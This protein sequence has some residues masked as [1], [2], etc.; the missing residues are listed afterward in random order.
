MRLTTQTLF[1][2]ALLLAL[3]SGLVACGSDDQLS[4]NEYMDRIDSAATVAGERG[5][6]LVADAVGSGDVTPVQ[7]QSFLA[8][9]LDDLRIPLQET[10]DEL[11]PPDQL[12]DLHERL[13][14]WHADLI[15]VETTLASRVGDTED[16]DAGW[17]ALSD[18]PEMEAYRATLAEGKELCDGFQAELDAI[19]AVGGFADVPWMPGELGGVVETALGCQWFPDRPADIYRYP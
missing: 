7:L 3:S 12:A 6:E 2:S 10:V 4:L 19:T 13:W 9:S 5:E 18:S 17:T 15:A 11:T 8:R 1:C 16:T 14:G